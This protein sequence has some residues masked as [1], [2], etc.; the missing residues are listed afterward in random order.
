MP[1]SG[2]PTAPPV[3]G[4][5]EGT[6]ATRD[7]PASSSGSVPVRELT[8]KAQPPQLPL[9]ICQVEPGWT[10]PSPG[11]VRWRRHILHRKRMRIPSGLCRQ[12]GR[13]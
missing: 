8:E 2:R 6:G 3:P 12:R 1:Q 7:E 10:L 11:G 13:L 5:R 4:A 9:G